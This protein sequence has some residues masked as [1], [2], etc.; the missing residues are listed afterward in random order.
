VNDSCA[1]QEVESAQ[2][3]VKDDDH[4]VRSEFSCSRLEHVNE[5]VVNIL[6]DKGHGEMGFGTIYK[7]FL[8]LGNKA[9]FAQLF[10]DLYLSKHQRQIAM[11]VPGH[12]HNLDSNL[13]ARRP[14][15]SFIDRSERSL[16]NLR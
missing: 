15:N 4:V 13:L 16:T 10:H 9:A 14:L 6:H 8:K 11:I 5:R 1:V 12:L 3:V 2:Q 7:Y